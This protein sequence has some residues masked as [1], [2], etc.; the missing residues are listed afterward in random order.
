M[1]NAHVYKYVNIGLDCLSGFYGSNCKY[2]CSEN[3]IYQE[4]D[5]KTGECL[6]GCQPGWR[7]TKCDESKTCI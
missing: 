4:C 7:N 6:N 2:T 1:F 5:G 3:C